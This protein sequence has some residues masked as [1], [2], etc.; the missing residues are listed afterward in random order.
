MIG[1]FQGF[2]GAEPHRGA[3]PLFSKSHGAVRCSLYFFRIIRCGAVRCGAVRSGAV[4]CGA[5]RCGAVPCRAVS[6]KER[7]Y[8]AVSLGEKPAR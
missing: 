1:I 6:L 2:H 4:R 8:G 5:V 3:V 7:S